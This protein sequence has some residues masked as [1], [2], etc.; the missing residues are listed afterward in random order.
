MT[1]GLDDRFTDRD[2][3]FGRVSED[4]QANLTA[5]PYPDFLEWRQPGPGEHVLHDFTKLDQDD[6]SIDAERSSLRVATRR[7]F[8]RSLA[9]RD[10]QSLGIPNVPL[11]I[12]P[13]FSVA[14]YD[15]LG[16][17][18]P[19]DPVQESYQV[20]DVLTL[21]RGRHIIKAGGDF[22]RFRINDLQLNATIF[23]FSQNETSSPSSGAT[24]NPVSQPAARAS[25]SV[26]PD[27][28][29]GQ[30]Y[31]PIELPWPVCARHITK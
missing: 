17:A 10:I 6:Q 16:D 30:F 12:L 29:R 2:L 20:E 25:G 14:G 18:P 9:D 13:Q 31:S 3:F 27:P 4:R 19:F 8:S 28:I 7:A 23:S 24:G 5:R 21:V 15:S 1:F 22:R 11:Q 26:S